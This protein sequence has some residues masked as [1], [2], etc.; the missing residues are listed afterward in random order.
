ML[1]ATLGQ[2][3]FAYYLAVNAA[4][5]TGYIS[6]RFLKINLDIH[7]KVKYFNTAFAITTILLLVFVLSPNLPKV[8]VAICAALLIAYTGWQLLQALEIFQVSSPK[9]RPQT[10]TKIKH[11]KRP[12][13]KPTPNLYYINIAVVIIILFF[14]VFFPSI[15]PAKAVAS[16]VHYAPPHAWVNSLAWLKENTPEPF[17]DSNFYYQLYEAPEPGE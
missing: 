15:N 4:L 7:P 9:L 16:E 6:W 5:L 10:P 3:R 1:L 12:S 11:K 17:G 13:E 2:R 8:I 14:L